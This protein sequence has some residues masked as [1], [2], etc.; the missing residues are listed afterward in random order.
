[1]AE[2][3]IGNGLPLSGE[4]PRK[5]D[6]AKELEALWKAWKALG[7][8]MIGNWAGPLQKDTQEAW[9]GKVLESTLES[10]ESPFQTDE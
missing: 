5:R 2:Q 6:L 9:C 4:A 7:K 10:P 1:M 8:R 3:I